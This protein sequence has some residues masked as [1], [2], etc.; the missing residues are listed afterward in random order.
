MKKP[1]TILAA[2]L[3]AAFL[4]LAELPAGADE[5]APSAADAQVAASAGGAHAADAAGPTTADG[6]AVAAEGGAHAADS[7]GHDEGYK[8]SQWRE[9]LF[10]VLNFIVYAAILIFL[11]RKPV[12]AFFGGR[13]LDIARKVE[14]LE[15]QAKNYEEQAKV[16][17]RKLDELSLERDRLL[18]QYEVDGARDRDR[19]IEEAKKTAE[20][21][22]QR[23]E[24]A[25]QQEIKAARRILTIEAG[26]LAVQLAGDI[27]A[28]SVVD[29]DRTRLAH[30]FIEQVVKLPA[31]N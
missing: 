4:W 11:L 2:I 6:H 13:R 23:T 20:Q 25:M 22:I 17:H 3:V 26:E 10:R 31:K 7:G 24:L 19:I 8:P 5:A 29:E 1:V 21:I 16:M 30:E 12:A 27:L 14:Y 18:K 15:T 9:F 28:R